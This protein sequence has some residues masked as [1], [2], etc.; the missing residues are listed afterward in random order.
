MNFFDII[1][2]FSIY[3]VIWNS[4]SVLRFSH[5]VLPSGCNDFLEA[6]QKDKEISNELFIVKTI[7]FGIYNTL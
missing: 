1:C 7:K 3:F 5:L 2:F 4:N 6:M